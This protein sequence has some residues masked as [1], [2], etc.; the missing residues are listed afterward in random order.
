[1]ISARSF[2]R[3][4]LLACLFTCVSFLTACSEPLPV[5][6]TLAKLPADERQALEVLLAAAGTSAEQL[7]IWDSPILIENKPRA[8]AVKDNHLTGINLTGTT[9]AAVENLNRFPHLEVFLAADCKIQKVTAT[10]LAAL[11]KLTLSRNQLANAEGIGDLPK[12]IYLNLDGNQLTSVAALKNLPELANLNLSQNQL[13]EVDRLPEFPKLLYVN[14]SHNPLERMPPT[15]PK[16]G[17][18][19]TAEG[20]PPLKNIVEKLPETGSNPVPETQISCSANL[21]QTQYE[22]SGSCSKPGKGAIRLTTQRQPV[23]YGYVRG[24]VEMEVA[25]KQG[26]VR[27]YL[28]NPWGKGYVW[29]DA[30]PEQP[31]RLYGNLCTWSNPGKANT[32]L[33]G[34]VWES[35]DD[36]AQN[37]TFRL[38]HQ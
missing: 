31:A 35:P 25:V 20:N 29:A 9:L 28:E 1:M 19:L 12:L 10:N 27:V 16:R 8:L 6:E 15:R 4:P 13:T 3:F 33:Y 17:W 37:L 11:T 26:R 36:Q 21:T 5:K 30:T 2:L 22:C 34:W 14:L 7:Q 38:N 32:Y 24:T 18:S 23:V